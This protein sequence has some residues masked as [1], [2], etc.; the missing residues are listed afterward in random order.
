ML[1]VGSSSGTTAP[2]PGVD[3]ATSPTARRTRTSA[4]SSRGVAQARVADVG[5]TEPARRPVTASG[6]VRSRGGLGTMPSVAAGTGSTRAGSTRAVAAGAG[7]TEAVG[8][9]STR[10]ATSGDGSTGT[11]STGTVSTGTVSTGAGS[12]GTVT[13]GAGSTGAALTGTV[14]ATRAVGCSGTATA[15]GAAGPTATTSPRRAVADGRNQRTRST[16]KHSCG[17]PTPVSPT[18]RD[19][20]AQVPDSP[21]DPGMPGSVI[22]RTSRMRSR[23]RAA[24]TPA[25][26]ATSR[27]VRPSA[28]ARWASFDAAS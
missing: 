25:S 6:G 5:V 11:V 1:A 18:P 16:P 27:M 10:A 8:T 13:T 26:V 24:T 17:D 23:S 2:C 15:A 28:S 19:A 7:S 20:C 21:G 12:T 14:R 22:A 4:T 3:G 9:V